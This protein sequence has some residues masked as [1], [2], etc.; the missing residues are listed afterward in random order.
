[1]QVELT[2]SAGP[3]GGFDAL[4]PAGRNFVAQDGRRGNPGSATTPKNR[5]IS[6]NM[7]NL[8]ESG[9]RAQNA[10]S[11]GECGLIPWPDPAWLR[12]YRRLAKD[13]D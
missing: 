13:F 7:T 9:E 2:A 1:M 10:A 6:D 12:R 5:G 4:P 3:T 11:S 8:V